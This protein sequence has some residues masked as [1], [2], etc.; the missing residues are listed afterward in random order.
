[1]IFDPGTRKIDK[2]AFVGSEPSIL[3][4]DPEDSA[5]Y[6]YLAGEQNVARLQVA[7]ES[8]DLVFVADPVGGSNQ[9]DV[10]DMAVGSDGGLAIS[11]SGALALDGINEALPIR[12]TIAA[13]DNGVP[14]PAAD[15]N[16]Q[17][18]FVR[19][20]AAF[21][22]E[23]D[24]S[25][26]TLYAYNSLL[27]FF[28]LKREAISN[29]GVRWL[30]TTARL[31]SGFDTATGFAD[32]MLDTSNGRLV[33]PERSLVVGR[34]SD[35]WLTSKPA[36]VAPDSAS[37]RID[38]ITIRGILQFDI[39]THALLGRLPFDLGSPIPVGLLLTCAHALKRFHPTEAEH[40]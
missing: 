32:G 40:R 13:F 12:G 19:S 39:R 30:S 26:S 7:S 31:V 22:L 4:V 36:A 8:R 23:F 16:D 24:E 20:P 27:T 33:D 1:M 17:R 21:D 29:Q 34:F 2:I 5:V 37:G 9:Y 28:Q 10:V 6:A 11:Y 14:R 25:G 3:A 18:R 15:L 38:F 35:S